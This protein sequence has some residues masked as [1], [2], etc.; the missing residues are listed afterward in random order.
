MAN[1]H[2]VHGRGYPRVTI[3]MSNAS[4]YE[5]RSNGVNDLLTDW[6]LKLG[7]MKKESRVIELKIWFGEACSSM[8]INSPSM[9]G[10]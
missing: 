4:N 3:E 8:A 7:C 10:Q 9:L 5:S 2:E 6:T 1:P